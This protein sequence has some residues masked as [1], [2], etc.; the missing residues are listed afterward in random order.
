MTIRFTLDMELYELFRRQS[1]IS[2]DSR[3]IVPDSL[4]FALHGE[5]F[6]GNSYAENALKA[7]AAAAVV[8]DPSV[9]E[10]LRQQWPDR[11]AEV[12]DTLAALQELAARHRRELGI[13]ILAITGS[14]GKTTTKELVGRVLSR[15]F[16]TAVTQ[17]N[18]NNHI[19]VPLTLLAMDRSV[20]IGVVEMGASHPGE[21]ALLCSIARP[22]YGLITN[23]GKA[24]LEGFG[25]IEGVMRGKGELLDFLVASGGT[26]FWL[27]D[28]DCLKTMVESRPGLRAISYSAPEAIGTEPFVEAR[29]DGLSVRTRLV[30]DYNRSNIAAAIAVGLY[31]GIGRAEIVSA[32]ESYDPDNN[33]SQKRQTAFNTLIS[34]CY[35]AN[36]SSM[37]AALDN[38]LRE[39]DP[40]PK[41]VVLGDMGELGPYAAVEH[42][43]VIERLEQGGI[44]E[45]YLVGGHFAEAARGSRYRTFA[46]TEALA[47]YLDE[48]PIRN[49]LVLVKGSRA[50]RLEKIA[51]KL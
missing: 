11:C 16:R 31:F 5:R 47:R 19:G 44:E 6:D 35:N 38:F 14:N 34:D 36:P 8:D 7:G 18:L 9:A 27:N 40:R 3:H 29:W 10:T 30:G 13:P 4:F 37:Q 32:I 43:T 39:A 21:I 26:A 1:R 46:D 20:E 48:H 41:A 23:I 12:P 51:E 50:N 17:G 15:K 42:R 2:T 45:A 22:D 33:R 24:H 25:G 28:S 49:R